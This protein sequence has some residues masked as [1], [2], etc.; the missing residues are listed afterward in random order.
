M[1]ETTFTEA[2]LYP[3]IRKWLQ[4]DG[5]YCGDDQARDDGSR[6]WWVD[7]GTRRTRLDV[8][9]VKSIGG[10]HHDDIEL[11]GVEVK[12]HERA[13]IQDINQALG[14]RRFVDRVYFATPGPYRNEVVQEAVRFGI[15]LLSIDRSGKKWKVRV[16]LT[17]MVNTPHLERRAE[18]MTK[19]WIGKCRLCGL[20]FE[21]YATWNDEKAPSFVVLKRTSRYRE[22]IEESTNDYEPVVCADCAPLLGYTKQE[23]EGGFKWVRPRR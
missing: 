23:V 18:L 12:K 8:V 21:R 7:I 4:R 19:L 10:R 14:Y 22:A 9:G 2:D 1:A 13:T 3:C 6:R 16:V 17:A 11:V 15:G 20:F 5:Y